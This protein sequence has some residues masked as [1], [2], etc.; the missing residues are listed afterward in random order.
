M[1]AARG[2][3]FGYLGVVGSIGGIVGATCATHFA[4]QLLPI[5]V[6]A[7]VAG[8][9]VR[10]ESPAAGR[11]PRVARRR[12]PPA[13]R[14]LVPRA[15]CLVPRASC[16]GAALVRVLTLAR[17]AHSP[18]VAQTTVMLPGWRAVFF[19]VAVISLVLG[20]LVLRII[21]AMRPARWGPLGGPDAHDDSRNGVPLRNAASGKQH[22][23]GHDYL[24]HVP[25]MLSDFRE[26]LA[27]RSFVVISVQGIVGSMPWRCFAYMV[28]SPAA[29]QPPSVSLAAPGLPARATDA[30]MHAPFSTAPA[31]ARSLRVPRAPW[32]R[33]RSAALGSV[34]VMSCRVVFA[35][36]RLCLRR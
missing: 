26:V 3:A 12:P 18:R 25:G 22:P 11:R 32:P 17:H 27:V 20:W 30:G 23:A 14:C 8:S 15:S 24:A 36:Y 6:P 10:R 34:G 31:P 7:W 13:L 35:A 4:E 5:A 29:P 21:P 9:Q 1:P 33:Q 19:A 16:L 2:G 28:R